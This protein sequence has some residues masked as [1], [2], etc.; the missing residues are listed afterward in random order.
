M[1]RYPSA[2]WRR[3][4]WVIL[5]NVRKKWLRLEIRGCKH[6]DFMVDYTLVIVEPVE[7]EPYVPW[8]PK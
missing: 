3:G 7:E 8:T 6:I 1:T 4:N 2:F 5:R